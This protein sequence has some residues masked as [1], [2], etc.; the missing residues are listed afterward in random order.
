M[1]LTLLRPVMPRPRRPLPPGEPIELPVAPPQPPSRLSWSGR[2]RALTGIVGAG[3]AVVLLCFGV[4]W[5]TNVDQVR[6][7]RG[8][9]AVSTGGTAAGQADKA[10]EDRAAARRAAD[11]QASAAKVL[12]AKAADARAS[13]A[14]AAEA[15]AADRERVREEIVMPALIGLGLAGALDAAARAGLTDVTVCRAPDDEFP[16]RRSEWRVTGQNVA[17]GTRIDAG[18]RVC[19]T[20]AGRQL[21]KDSVR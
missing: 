2:H 12:A 13:A 18:R 10:A 9:G 3:A 1:R 5:G 8:S 6:L 17:A 7:G 11:D 14:R 4:G 19:L 21:I 15:R 20:A 16:V